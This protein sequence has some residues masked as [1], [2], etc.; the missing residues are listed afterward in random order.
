M[1]KFVDLHTH[2]TASD[3]RL[4]PADLVR[5]ADE[6]KLAAIAL[7]DHDTTDGL[8]AARAAAANLPELRFIS[9]IEVSAKFPAGSLHILGL[10]IDE[11]APSLVGLIQRLRQARNDRNPRIIEKLRSMGMDITM[12]DVLAT[13]SHS[14]VKIVTRLQIAD[15]LRRMGFV[16]TNRE[17]FGMYIANGAPAYVDKEFTPPADAIAAI[18]GAGGIA[19]LAHPPQLGYENTA[20]LRRILRS[21]IADGLGGVEVYHSDHTPE[22][23]RL[24]LDLA[25]EYKLAVAG[26][27]DFH[28][29]RKPDVHLGLPKV[30]LAAVT[31]RLAELIS[32]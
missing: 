20:Q 26:G 17:A 31:G 23:T 25:A 11:N 14:G 29:D 8:A 1:R 16:K 10:G 13:G 27:S 5:L 15:T 12:D 19:V 32:A 18:R 28:G 21:L 2:S 22:Q 24:Y 4:D 6:R 9:G 7:T 3:G 30:P